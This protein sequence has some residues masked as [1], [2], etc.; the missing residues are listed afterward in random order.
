[1]TTA[2]RLVL[3]D[4]HF[5]LREF[6]GDIQGARWR[7]IYMANVALLRAVYHVLESRDVPTNAKLNQSFNTWKVELLRTK[8]TPEIYWKFIV[9]E[10]NQILKEYAATRVTNSVVSDIR[11]DL[12]TGKA[13]DLG[14]ARQQYTMAEGHFAGQEQRYLIKCAI[15][16]W[17]LELQ[18]LE[19]ASAA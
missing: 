8:P 5:A 16:W 18:K 11:F 6:A 9:D 1:M 10:R 14:N 12:S 4:C 17:E 15:E 7:I 19:R 13:E 2:A 3:Q